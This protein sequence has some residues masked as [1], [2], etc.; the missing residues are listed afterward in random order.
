MLALLTDD[1]LG[2]LSVEV[3]AYVVDREVK[4]VAAQDKSEW[5]IDAS[6]GWKWKDFTRV[7][8]ASLKG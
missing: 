6:T 8:F 7:W 2:K 3:P 5:R 1:G 4:A